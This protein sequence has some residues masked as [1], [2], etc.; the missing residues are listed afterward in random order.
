ML[1]FPRP[2]RG[3]GKEIRGIFIF[4]GLTSKISFILEDRFTLVTVQSFEAEM[5]KISLWCV[6]FI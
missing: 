5:G 2:T 1:N 6:F 3:L 4:L